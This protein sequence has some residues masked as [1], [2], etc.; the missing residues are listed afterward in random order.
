MDR[1]HNH[2]L[3]PEISALIRRKARILSRSYGFK[4]GDEEDIRQELAAHI[5]EK[6]R[7]HDPR[8][9][10][11][12]TFVDCLLDSKAVDLLRYVLARKRDRRREEPPDTDVPDRDLEELRDKAWNLERVELAMD[13]WEALAD[14]PEDVREVAGLLMVYGQAEV[15]RMTRLSREQVRRMERRIARHLRQRGLP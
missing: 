5:I 6:L 10:T 7:H 9:A 4:L 8:R 11:T 2:D 13:V 3:D 1:K 12:P 15:A 14:L